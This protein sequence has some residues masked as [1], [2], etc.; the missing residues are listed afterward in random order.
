MNFMYSFVTEAVN[1]SGK[2]IPLLLNSNDTNGTAVFNPSVY[3]DNGKL[4]VNIRHC[5]YT[6]FH[7]EKGR[8]PHDYGPL[9]YLNPED[10][11]TLT[12]TN[13][14]GELD[15][16]YNLKSYTKVD[17][18]RFDVPPL[19]EFI[20]LEDCRLFRW[21]NKL[22]L[23]GVR[24]DTKTNGE[25]RMELSELSEN[26]KE[27][28]RW[29]IP[30]PGNNDSYCEKNWM[31]ILD[32]PYHFVK[33]C[34]PLEIVQVDPSKGTCKT[35]LLKPTNLTKDY[36]GG[37]QVISLGDYYIA[38]THITRLWKTESQKKN[39]KYTH[40]FLVWD[41]NWNFIKATE[42]FSLMNANIEFACGMAV[43]NNDV[44]IS[45]GYQDNCAFLLQI[46][47]DF[48]LEYIEKN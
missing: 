28:S 1:A 13:Y 16:N 7:S 30:A 3:N 37:S 39:A 17:T 44:L 32:M 35:V 22:Y 46:T 21:D 41:K 11:I 26:G 36:R 10:D 4:R 8:F 31:P 19:W 9:L 48:L 24:R 2:L 15:Q 29:R 12:T 45:F 42:E 6:L 27:I 23:C 18:S 40:S 38:L 43:N 14:L 20:G 34:N 47:K 25:G 5:Q 33:W